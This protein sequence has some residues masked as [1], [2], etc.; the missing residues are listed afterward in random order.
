VCLDYLALLHIPVSLLC[1]V[2]PAL[3]ALPLSC[4]RVVGRLS[5]ALMSP[6]PLLRQNCIS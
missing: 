5:R 6:S 3:P 1:L 2:S 4:S